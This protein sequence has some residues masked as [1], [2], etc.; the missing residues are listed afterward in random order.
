MDQPAS[1]L[2][3]L[4]DALRAPAAPRPFPAAQWR[5]L[6]PQGWVNR[7]DLEDLMLAMD[8]RLWS[9]PL[10][11]LAEY[12]GFPARNV[13]YKPRFA[14]SDGIIHAMLA[15]TDVAGFG[16]ALEQLGFA[17]D[18]AAMV[19][20]LAAQVGAAPIMT[21]AEVDI[22]TYAVLRHR[23]RRRLTA[24]QRPDGP[25]DEST[26]R[27]FN[28]YRYSCLTR[29]GVV[30]ALTV[31]GPK[32]RAPR[33][34]EVT[35]TVCGYRYTQGDPESVL[36]HRT[37]HARVVRLLSPR[38]TKP[39]RLRLAQGRAAGE[40][41]DV[42][43]PLWLHREVYE[44]AMRFK[45][46]FGYDFAQWHTVNQRS[47]LDPRWV[48]FVFADEAGAI[49]GACAFMRVEDGWTL[50]WVWV[51]PALR[52]RG[53]LAARWPAYLEEF[54]DF[55]IEHPLSEAMAGFVA[56]HASP[57]QLQRIAERYPR[58]STIEQ[59]LTNAV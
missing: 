15:I 9:L 50:C 26:W 58:G 18:P 55:W 8:G 40:R 34:R 3:Q 5:R 30:A 25:P 13:C 16:I 31:R 19:Q 23:L 21:L 27:G 51:R 46:D 42:H 57:G 20:A 48:G 36:H 39:M 49:D 1:L 28:G 33:R 54:G 2:T 17:V 53:L 41:V 44:R 7:C 4:A 45:R 10:M 14:T 56:R 59:P 47:D 12:L 52:R 37:E 22:H 24:D 32:Y 29:G 11:D 43:A 38:P 35:C 6:L